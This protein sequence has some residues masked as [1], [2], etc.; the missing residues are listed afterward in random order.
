MDVKQKISL[1]PECGACPEVEI[2]HDNGA[3][4]SPDWGRRSADHPSQSCLEHLRPV[5]Q[6]GDTA[7]AVTGIGG[8]GVQPVLPQ[9]YF[10]GARYPM[11]SGGLSN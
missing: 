7:R 8:V 2:L 11:T 10:L 1:C 6:G 5:C 4:G 9:P 3:G